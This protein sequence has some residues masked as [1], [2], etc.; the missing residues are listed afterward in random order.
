MKIKRREFIAAIPVGFLMTNAFGIRSV[1]G[2][3]NMY[4]LIG[5]L[6]A[7]EGK[8]DELIRILLEG[9]NEMPG[10]LSYIV[11]KDGADANTIW[12]TEVWK[13]QASHK[14][15][16]SLPVV[17]KAIAKGKPLIAGF[18][19]QIVI[20]PVGGYGLQKKSKNAD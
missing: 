8:R 1:S 2:K 20:E 3:E 13:D 15:S 14:A 9:T 12:I 5:K 6:I 16:L 4:G 7:V 19:D 18:G 10:C 11:G 17:Q